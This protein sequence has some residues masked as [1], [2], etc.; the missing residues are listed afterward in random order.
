MA[1]SESKVPKSQGH[2]Q[3][4]NYSLKVKIIF[5]SYDGEIHPDSRGLVAIKC[6]SSCQKTKLTVQIDLDVG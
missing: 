3:P 6:M 2:T 1:V 5:Q 4:I